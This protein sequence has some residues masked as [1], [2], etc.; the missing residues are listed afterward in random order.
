MKIYKSKGKVLLVDIRLDAGKTMVFLLSHNL[1][2]KIKKKIIRGKKE[3]IDIRI[4]PFNKDG[5]NWESEQKHS[6]YTGDI[7]YIYERKI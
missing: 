7:R 6:Y 4:E 5:S 2:M 3:R 1:R